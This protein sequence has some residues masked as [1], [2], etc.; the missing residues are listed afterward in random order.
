MVIMPYN[1]EAALF[2]TN[3]N[4]PDKARRDAGM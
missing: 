3:V 2:I 1:E 4:Q